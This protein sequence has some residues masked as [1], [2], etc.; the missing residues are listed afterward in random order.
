MDA[1]T[2]IL[3]L[4]GGLGLFIYGMQLCSEGLQKAAARRMKILLKTLTSNPLLGVLMGVC[5]TVGLQGSGAASALIVGFVSANLIT[6]SQALEV[7]IGSAIGTSVTSQLIAFKITGF[8]LLLLFVGVIL[9]MFARRSRWKSIGRTVLGFGLLFYGMS[10]MSTSMAPVKDYPVI[11]QTLINLEKYPILEFLM[12]MVITAILQSSPAFLALLMSL[13]A[14]KLIGPYALIP[15]VLGAHLG[16]TVTGLISSIGTPGLDAK[17]AA[18]ANFGF[19]LINGSLFLPF[20][21]PLTHLLLISSWDLDREIANAHTFFSLIMA[22][23]FLPFTGLAARLMNRLIPERHPDLGEAVYLDENLLEIP[24]LA[25]DHARLQTL[26]MGRIVTD[27]MLSRTLPAIRDGDEDLLEQIDKVEPAI[28][29]LY[30]KI[31]CYV[32]G[33]GNN[34]ISDELMQQS[35][36]ILYTANDLEH[37][38]DIMANIVKNARKIKIEGISFSEEGLEELGSMF[39]QV[40]ERFNLALKAFADNDQNLATRIIKEHPKI[41]RL[42]KEMR[43]NHFDRMQYGNQKTIATSAVHLDLIEGF[44]RIDGHAVNIAQV[45]VGIV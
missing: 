14:H 19:K 32:T 24:E 45:V 4:A 5:V 21:R 25:L 40:F 28:D 9:Y 37:I 30:K 17:R 16:G 44:L 36:Q 41:L 29:Q 8:A 12:A 23:G 15:F 3:G 10:V 27:Q 7:L 13:A 18:I 1:L 34:R 26:E 2:S 11:V 33:L 20:Y 31:S 35:I 6:L 39:Q 42:E 38:G 22:L 43:Y